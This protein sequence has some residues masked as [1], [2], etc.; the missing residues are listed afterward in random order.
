[1]GLDEVLSVDW[2]TRALGIG[3]RGAVIMAVEEVDRVETTASKV[4]IR[5]VTQDADGRMG[6]ESLLVKGNFNPDVEYWSSSQ[7]NRARFFGTAAHEA[8]FYRD[9]APFVPV[10][11]PYSPYAGVDET[12]NHGVVLLEDLIVAGA[13]FPSPLEVRTPEGVA[14]AMG[15]FAAL[16]AQFWG[17]QL[18]GDPWMVPK[19]PGYLDV[20]GM[21]EWDALLRGARG[22]G[23]PEE[24]RQASRIRAGLGAL[25]TWYSSRPKTLVH[26]D[27]H[28]G[29]FYITASGDLGFTDWQNYEFGHWSMDIAYHVAGSLSPEDRRANEQELLR[30][31]LTHLR[32]AG[33]QA[34]EFDEAWEDFRVSVIYGYFL[35][36]ITRRVYEPITIEMNRRLG[37][38]VTE[39]ESLGRLGV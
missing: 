21:E 32:A 8:R 19:Y 23:I 29:N 5:V 24:T 10:T 6:A 4:R 25:T 33:V 37:T 13:V 14:V 17:D 15:E 38:A 12:T 2:L 18:A 27:A 34:P 22:K 9:L 31:Y 28:P 16:H 30:E 3:E 11:V 39:H 1:M 35:W 20:I 7:A 26:A 36:S